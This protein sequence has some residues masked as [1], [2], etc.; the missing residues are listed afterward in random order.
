MEGIDVIVEFEKVNEKTWN[1]T[2]C[3]TGSQGTIFQS[4]YWA[5]YLSKTYGDRPIYIASLDKNGNIRGLLLAMESCYA[6]YPFLTSLGKRNQ[7]FGKLYERAISPLFHRL[8][9]FIFWEHAPLILPHPSVKEPSKKEELLREMIKRIMAISKERNCYEI[10]LARSPLFDSY[11]D[12]FSSFNFYKRRMGTFLINLEEQLDTLWSRISKYSRNR[13]RK[14]QENVEVINVTN[15][16]ELKDFYEMH[17]QTS[18]RA[19][20]KTYPYSYFTSLWD[21]LSKKGAIAVFIAKSKGKLLAGAL[22]LIFNNTIYEFALV[23][24]DYNRAMKMF[25]NAILKW[26]I[27]NW[28]RERE[29]KY[30]NLGGVELHKI[31]SGDKKARGIYR[32]KSKWGGKLLEFYDYRKVNPRKKRVISLLNKCLSDSTVA[33]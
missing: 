5:E 6:K 13:I 27:I 17:I 24:S 31:D 16:K 3:E 25:A 19:K 28:G 26:H 8:V 22:E 7:I 4:T 11:S 12:A 20:I 10:K 32:Y 30:Y 2:V 9:P 1:N 33:F 21:N 23:D 15:R 29:F 18:K 14:F